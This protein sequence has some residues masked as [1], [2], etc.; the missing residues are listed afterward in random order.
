MPKSPPKPG[1]VTRIIGANATLVIP[2]K[3]LTGSKVVLSTTAGF[4][5]RLACPGFGE[6]EW[7]QKRFSR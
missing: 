1:R 6:S 3:S 4:R 7:R 2:A 5:V